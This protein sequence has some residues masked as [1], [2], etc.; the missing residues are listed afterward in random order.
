MNKSKGD[1]LESYDGGV[2]QKDGQAFQKRSGGSFT[3][4]VFFA[5]GFLSDVA[6]VETKIAMLLSAG[7]PLQAIQPGYLS[8]A[9]MKLPAT[10]GTIAL[11]HNKRRST[12]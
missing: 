10:E 8:F 3:M 6:L 12:N 1:D 7:F 5:Q 11:S 9:G 4:R 2:S